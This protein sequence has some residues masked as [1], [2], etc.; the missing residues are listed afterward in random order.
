[1]PVASIGPGVVAAVSVEVFGAEQPFAEAFPGENVHH[2]FVGQEQGR[3]IYA[4]ELHIPA[5]YRILSHAHPYDHLS[6]L[7]RGVIE[8]TAGEA[9]QTLMGPCAISVEAGVVHALCALTDVV[10]FCVHPT[11]E[12]D[13]EAIDTVILQGD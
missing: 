6:I 11:E 3:G 9:Q 7:A 12:T 13:A 1:M 10:W 5:G 2:H 8:W 4:K